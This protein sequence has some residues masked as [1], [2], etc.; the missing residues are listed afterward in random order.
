MIFKEWKILIGYI[1]AF[2]ILSS[3]VVSVFEGK[4][5]ATVNAAFAGA[6][7]AVETVVGFLGVMCMWMGL[8][9]IAEMSGLISIF[10]RFI[11]PVTRMIFPR[12][13]KDSPAQ[14]AIS[15]NIVAN[16]LGLG[17][18]A[19]P[20]G[21]NAMERLNE[22]NP[23][24]KTATNEMC[25]LVVLNTASIQLI[26]STLIALRSTFGSR[27]PSEIILPVWI[28]SVITA[29][30]AVSVTA[31]FGRKQNVIKKRK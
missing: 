14:K 25:M 26:P 12:I 31:Y 30:I 29:I 2:M 18:A 19:T 28:S 10:S 4:A 7:Q 17:N 1:W 16:I 3:L 27:N 13:K 8:M 21:I 6:N 23:D 11:S 24:K 20:L 5:E 22:S 9:K 15:M